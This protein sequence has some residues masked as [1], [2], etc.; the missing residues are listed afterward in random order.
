[1]VETIIETKTDLELFAKRLS[2]AGQPK[3]P[4]Q[5]SPTADELADLKTTLQTRLDSGP[6]DLRLLALEWKYDI[7]LLLDHM[8]HWMYTVDRDFDRDA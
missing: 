1:M 3:R 2:R 6:M 7:A 5:H 4:S 8:R